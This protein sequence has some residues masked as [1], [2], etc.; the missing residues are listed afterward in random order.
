[1]RQ[2]DRMGGMRR[3]DEMPSRGSGEC[4]CWASRPW[5]YLPLHPEA[6]LSAEERAVVQEWARGGSRLAD[7]DDN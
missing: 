2:H 7:D 1:M 3:Q 4:T 5:L 6:R